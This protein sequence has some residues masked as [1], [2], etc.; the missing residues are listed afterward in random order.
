MLSCVVCVCVR[1]Y[2]VYMCICMRVMYVYVY[3]YIMTN[4]HPWRLPEE[5]PKGHTF[6]SSVF[7]FYSL[8]PVSITLTLLLFH[9]PAPSPSLLLLHPSRAAPGGAVD[10]HVTMQ[11]TR[12]RRRL[13]LKPLVSVVLT[14]PGVSEKEQEM[15][16]PRQC[17]VLICAGV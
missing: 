17:I 13:G 1:I 15:S 9:P 3:K 5:T 14:C 2:Y 7:I 8:S 6:S 11:I 10:Q 4:L 16:F 12:G